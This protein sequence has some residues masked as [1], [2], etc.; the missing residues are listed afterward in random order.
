MW[1]AE[2][3]SQY[4]RK[5]LRYRSDF[6]EADG[7]SLVPFLMSAASTK[8]ARVARTRSGHPQWLPIR[9][10][11]RMPLARPAQGPAAQKHRAWLVRALAL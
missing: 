3:R 5:G 2:N 4:A 10:Q 1:T 6:T 8:A 7:T 11:Q 9:A